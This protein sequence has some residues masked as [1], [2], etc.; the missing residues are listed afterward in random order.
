MGFRNPLTLLSELVADTITGAVIQT[1]AA[2]SRLVIENDIAGGLLKFFTGNASEVNPGS[3]NP[4]SAGSGTTWQGTLSLMAPGAAAGQA[5]VLLVSQ[6]P[7]GTKPKSIGLSGQIDSGTGY[8]IRTNARAHT[9]SSSPAL[10][11]EADG[12]AARGSLS[13]FTGGRVTGVNTDASSQVVVNHSLGATPDLLTASTN[14]AQQVRVVGRTST[15][16]T[17]EFRTTA[18]ALVGAGVG[19]S[20][21]WLA[22]IL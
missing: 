14:F 12:G 7:D 6:S 21:D 13:G 18:G 8:L 19:V 9:A 11:F 4:G 16:F 17:L 2:G 1:A 3:I 10:T 5:S 22:A 15:Q 20:V